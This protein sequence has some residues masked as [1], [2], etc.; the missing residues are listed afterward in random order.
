MENVSAEEVRERLLQEVAHLS[1]E[2]LNRKKDEET[3]SIGQICE[4][5]SL[6]DQRVRQTIVYTMNKAEKETASVKTN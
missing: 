5:L 1:E 3:W 6:M 4:H 2:E